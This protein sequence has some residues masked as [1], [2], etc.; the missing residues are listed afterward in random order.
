MTDFNSL[1]LAD[2]LKALEQGDELHLRGGGWLPFKEYDYPSKYI[3]S[4][5]YAWLPGGF[6][7]QKGQHSTDII[8]VIRPSARKVPYVIE[9]LRD[10]NSADY[11]CPATGLASILLNH[12]ENEGTP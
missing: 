6:I 2:Q 12:F 3:V 9:V 10:F 4:H 11:V 1:P 5:H 7:N 8:R